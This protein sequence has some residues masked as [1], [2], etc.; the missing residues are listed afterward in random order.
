MFFQRAVSR[1]GVKMHLFMA[2]EQENSPIGEFSRD[3]PCG[4]RRTR[5]RNPV[6]KRLRRP[7]SRCPACPMWPF[8][9]GLWAC[10]VRPVDFVQAVL[11]RKVYSWSTTIGLPNYLPNCD[12]H[13]GRFCA[14]AQTH[15]DTR[16][17][18]HAFPFLHAA[19]NAQYYKGVR[20]NWN[21]LSIVVPDA[22]FP[23]ALPR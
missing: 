8:P 2:R 1:A 21:L 13:N 19:P 20:L 11:R 9:R 7:C 12:E 18:L 22:F 10:R 4:P 5:T 6:L 17:W 3:F 16:Y 15:I 23:F 14:R